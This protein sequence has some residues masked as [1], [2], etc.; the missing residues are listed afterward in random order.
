MLLFVILHSSSHVV[1]PC[2]VIQSLS[3]SVTACAG[4]TPVQAVTGPVPVSVLVAVLGFLWELMPGRYNGFRLFRL[5]VTVSVSL[6]F[7]PLLSSSLP[8]SPFPALSRL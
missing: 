4:D 2:S 5:V 7:S 3:V 1:D 6:L 8:S